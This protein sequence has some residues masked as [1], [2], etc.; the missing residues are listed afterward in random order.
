MP[1]VVTFV[2]MPR[3]FFTA[4]PKVKL[5][6]LLLAVLPCVPGV[7]FILVGCCHPLWPA[8]DMTPAMWTSYH[9]AEA[10]ANGLYKA[11]AAALGMGLL[12]GAVVGWQILR[13]READEDE[14][15]EAKE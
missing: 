14:D 11:G 1:A 3:L 6:M 10:Q 8:Q 4:P 5:T 2:I 9:R 7:T 15:R 12:C 13:Q